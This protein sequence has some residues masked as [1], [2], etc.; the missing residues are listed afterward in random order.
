MSS[1]SCTIK[2]QE[3][4]RSI[5]SQTVWSCLIWVQT[6][7]SP[8]YFCVTF[9]T[10]CSVKN[11]MQ[12]YKLQQAKLN[13]FGDKRFCHYDSLKCLSGFV[14]VIFD[15]IKPNVLLYT[16]VGV[17]SCLLIFYNPISN[18]VVTL[19]SVLETVCVHV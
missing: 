16:E 17:S 7:A 11:C 12:G 15:T 9:R 2:Y 14:Y 6:V 4:F 8:Q 1:L 19:T 13:I 10:K 5:T 3:N 18:D